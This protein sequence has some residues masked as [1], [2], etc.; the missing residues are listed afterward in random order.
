MIYD[1]SKLPQNVQDQILN[2]PKYRK[3]FSQKPKKLLALDGNAKTIKGQKA[4][5]MT[6]ILYLTPA[7]GSGE[8]VCPMAVMA[9]CEAPCL[10]TA[11]RGA[12]GSVQLARL[13][14]TLFF[15]QYKEEFIA[16]IKREI[17]TMVKKITKKGYVPLVRLNGTSDIRWENYGI[18]QAFPDVQFY[19]YTKIANRK[20]IPSNYDLTFS[21]SGIAAYLPFVKQA[22][23]AGMRIATVFR[24]RSIVERML[25]NQEQ[26]MG[27][28]VVDGDDT[29]IRHLDP[30]GVVVALYAK[31]KAKKDTSGFVFG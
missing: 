6:A 29:D 19:D 30:M 31:G 25:E 17:A 24:T 13:R 28:Q 20:N 2:T 9:G 1:L 22:I 10:N 12:M 18:P 23:A 8:N 26:V 7:S 11:G 5:F 16:Q 21:Y 3:M 27:M 14:K 15:N 4:G